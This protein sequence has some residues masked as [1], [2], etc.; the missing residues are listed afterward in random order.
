MIKLTVGKFTVVHYQLANGNLFYEMIT[1]QSYQSEYD[2]VFFFN[3]VQILSSC[4]PPFGQRWAMW[5]PIATRSSCVNAV[6]LAAPI[7]LTIESCIQ[8]DFVKKKNHDSLKYMYQRF[9]NLQ[10]TWI[11]NVGKKW[12][13]CVIDLEAMNSISPSSDIQANYYYHK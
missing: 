13:T 7:S 1:Y 10:I 11:Y 5:A 2:T 8:R 12:Y 6:S 9:I 4:M 3:V